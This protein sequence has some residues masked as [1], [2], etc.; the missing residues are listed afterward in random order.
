MMRRLGSV[1]A[2]RCAPQ[3]AVVLAAPTAVTQHRN[4]EFMSTYWLASWGMVW[5][6]N[7]FTSFPLVVMDLFKPSAVVNKAPLLH[8]FHEKRQ[9]MKLQKALD[10]TV[11]EWADEL[12]VASIDD[13]ISRTF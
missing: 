13:A 9:E 5:Q 6:W 12:D 2:L 10:K 4:L 7:F 3:T 1:A 11:T 8:Y